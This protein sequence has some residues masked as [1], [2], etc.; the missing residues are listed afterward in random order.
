[1]YAANLPSGDTLEFCGARALAGAESAA[2]HVYCW[3]SQRQRL[4]CSA[5]VIDRLSLLSSNVGR[6]LPSTRP[7]DAAASAAASLGWSNIAWRLRRAGSTTEKAPPFG[8]VARYQ[9]RP[10]SSH[11][12]RP[13]LPVT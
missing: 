12:G 9:N 13:M 7:P 6:R 8:T 5:T 4:F 1:M 3:R 11:V 2:A 10:S